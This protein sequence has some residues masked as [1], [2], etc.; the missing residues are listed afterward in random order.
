MITLYDIWRDEINRSKITYI[1]GVPRAFDTCPYLC[2]YP[3]LIAG[4]TIRI[5][6]NESKNSLVNIISKI[7]CAS[8][9]KVQIKLISP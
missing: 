2:L 5:A 7:L 3:G 6:F 9:S 8:M 1:R 4:A